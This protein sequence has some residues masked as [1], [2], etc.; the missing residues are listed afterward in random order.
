MAGTVITITSGKGGVGKSTTS[1]NLATALALAGQR[2]VVIDADIGLRNLDIIMGLESRIVYNLVDVVEGRCELHQALIRDT[3]A[4]ELY[5]LAASQTR[6]KD[7]VQ[8]DQMVDICRELQQIADY[9][10]IDSPAGIE[11]GFRNAVAAADEVFLVTTPE[12]SALRD[13]DKVIFLLERDT[14]LPPRLVI[15]RYNA[16]LVRRGDM[17]TK[18]DILDIL[19]ID[20]LG[21]VPEDDDIV[22]ST[23][24]GRPI[25]LDRDR[26]VSRAYHN[27]AQRVLGYNVPLLDFNERSL[28]ERL[29][30]W[31]G[32]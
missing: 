18:D 9:V 2:V 14:S 3:R 29:R 8:P 26:F 31:F 21:I 24:K 5:L 28:V 27:I 20:L 17:L 1:A 12:V 11:L 16:R 13:A 4:G 30:L 32:L 7:A 15:N 6:D 23:N 10:L 22:I 25:A 19:S